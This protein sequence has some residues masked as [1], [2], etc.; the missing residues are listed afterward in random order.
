[1]KKTDYA[2]TG[3]VFSRVH[4]L[5][6][7]GRYCCDLDAY[8]GE[9][10]Q[11]N[12]ILPARI[13]SEN[14]V[15]S[16]YQLRPTFK[17]N[18]IYDF[19]YKQSDRLQREL[20]NIQYGTSVWYQKQLADVLGAKFFVV[21]ADNGRLPLTF[22]DVRGNKAVLTGVLNTDTPELVQEFWKCKLGL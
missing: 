12:R 4:R 7:D 17:T 3:N 8:D 11:G 10:K 19:K 22:Y 1:M 16:E 13:E 2:G 6:E 18:V 9:I 5:L 21:I 14:E 15:Y 20:S